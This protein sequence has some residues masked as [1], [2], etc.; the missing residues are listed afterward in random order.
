M[1]VTTDA[2][3]FGAW[4]SEDIRKQE[5]KGSL[6]D[7]GTGTGLCSLMIAQKNE[8]LMIDAIEIDAAAAGQALENV[9]ASAY[10]AS[11]KVIHG[12]ASG[13]AYKKKYDI[14][15]SNP[16][17][18]D[19]DLTSPDRRINDARHN[20]GLKT[21]KL[22]SIFSDHLSDNGDVYLLLP[23]IRE[24]E[25][26]DLL[27]KNEFF[28]RKRI[29][30]FQTPGHPHFRVMLHFK[31]KHAKHGAVKEN[32]FIKDE[33]GNYSAAFTSLLQDYYLQL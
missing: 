11:V 29:H 31:L 1:K 5:L 15:I 14:I 9:T 27:E 26:C 8:Q 2:C 12:D 24:K 13:H 21:E 6:L 33:N 25:I 30:V 22:I 3:L 16:P 19:N 23:A 28:I 7:V 10:S 17:F 20:T 4:A 18:Y 32:I